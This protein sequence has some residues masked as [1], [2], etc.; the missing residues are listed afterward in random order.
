VTPD[1]AVI[2]VVEGDPA[3]RRRLSRFLRQAGY[4]VVT[5]SGV[6]ASGVAASGVAASGVAASGVAASGVAASGVAASGVAASVA[7]SGVAAS[8]A[9]SGVAASGVAAGAEL[10]HS[11]TFGSAGRPF[12]AC[13]VAVTDRAGL[14]AAMA[15]LPSRTGAVIVLAP[16]ARV[17]VVEALGAGADDYLAQP[18]DPDELLARLRALLRRAGDDR[19]PPPMV[20]TDFTLDLG[21]RR[22]TRRGHE[23]HLTPTEWQVLDLLA[24]HPGRLVSHDQML[25]SIW[26]PGKVDRL[27]YLRVYVASL[28]RKL[29]PDRT[30]P[31]YLLT[32]P[33]YGYRLQVTSRT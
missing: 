18:A 9:A 12:D 32:E 31:R 2:E 27:V 7:A 16:P 5:A 25:R 29:E 30:E 20:T 14:A 33:G 4:R 19:S 13:I 3:S 23:V 8:V 22:L 6:A 26:G 17:D 11:P 24:R 10:G 21:E 15:A 1:R 28:R